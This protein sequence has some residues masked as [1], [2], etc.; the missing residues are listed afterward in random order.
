MSSPPTLALPVEA[1][2]HIATTG[3][4]VDNNSD[5]CR[6]APEVNVHT[7][8]LLNNQFIDAL[9]VSRSGV[10]KETPTI[11]AETPVGLLSKQPL[12][13]RVAEMEKIIADVMRVNNQVTP[14]V[15]GGQEAFMVSNV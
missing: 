4:E 1:S 15:R 11:T 13:V 14:Y 3:G 10:V 8:E 7:A 9:A 6:D 12:D 2:V 5:T